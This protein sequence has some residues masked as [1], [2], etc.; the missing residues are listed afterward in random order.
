MSILSFINYKQHIQIMSF[1]N[2]SAYQDQLLNTLVDRK[3]ANVSS[4]LKELRVTLNIVKNNMSQ[5]KQTI[6]SEV[7]KT[8]KALLGVGADLIILKKNATDQKLYVDTQV[9]N[10]SKEL[11]TLD[12][13]VLSVEK[14]LTTLYT[15]L[16]PLIAP[17]NEYFAESRLLKTHDQARFIVSNIPNFITFT[18]RLE[19]IYR[20]STH[21][22]NR[23][24]FHSRVDN[25][26]PTVSLV[27]SSKNKLSAGYTSVSWQSPQSTVY[28]SDAT[29]WLMQL[30]TLTKYPVT[31]SDYAVALSS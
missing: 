24:N 6:D 5:L 11:S 17:R 20:G 2:T 8:S 9:V 28:K 22:W 27:L 29:A 12:S 25:K 31:N 13:A 23:T 19:L 16:K 26:G 15:S 14:H 3:F 10:V 1:Q 7:S 18:S 4:D 30:D 21:G